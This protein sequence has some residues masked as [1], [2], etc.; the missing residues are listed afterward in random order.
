MK[1]GHSFTNNLDFKSKK[2]ALV[3][4]LTCLFWPALLRHCQ[5]FCVRTGWHFYPFEVIVIPQSENIELFFIVSC[6]FYLIS[7]SIAVT[8]ERISLET[9]GLM[10]KFFGYKWPYT[11]NK[12]TKGFSIDQWAKFHLY[13]I[14]SWRLAVWTITQLTIKIPARQW[15][16]IL[17]TLPVIYYCVS[18]WRW[19]LKLEEAL[20]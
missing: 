9:T 13:N 7:T 14:V 2:T 3:T 1:R 17:R 11:S 20:S 18:F 19:P 4:R 16:P 15:T 5:L 6:F 12:Y 10:L 8:K